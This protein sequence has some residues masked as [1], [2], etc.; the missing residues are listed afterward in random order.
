M[1]VSPAIKSE[2][3]SRSSPL[4]GT[5]VAKLTVEVFPVAALEKKVE[6]YR[7]VT[8][9]NHTARDL[10]LTI[11]GKAVKLPAKTYLETKLAQAFKW[12]Y[13]D[14]PTGS[15]CVPDGAAGLEVVF[16]E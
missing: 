16:R 12:G 1:P 6:G 7:T 14:R 9:Y 8:F 15:E 13:G 5:G 4:T 2:S 11:E 10:S 3:K